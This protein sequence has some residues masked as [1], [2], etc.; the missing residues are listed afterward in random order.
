MMHALTCLRIVHNT[1]PTELTQQ[2]NMFHGLLFI[3]QH[4][5]KHELVVA[6]VQLPHLP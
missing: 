5:E 4:A 2:I 6:T 3:K 1:P